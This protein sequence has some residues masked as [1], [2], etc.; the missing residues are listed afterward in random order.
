MTLYHSARGVNVYTIVG[1][2]TIVDGVVSGF[3]ANGYL[4]FSQ[5]VAA[6]ESLE[7]VLQLKNIP[8][9]VASSSAICS[10]SGGTNNI[11]LRIYENTSGRI[12]A[13]YVDANGTTVYFSHTTNVS[14]G[15]FKFSFTSTTATESYSSDGNEWTLLSTGSAAPRSLNAN[16]VN[17]GYITSS[18]SDW[19][20]SIDLKG[21]YIKVDEAAYFGVCPILVQKH[22]LR[23]PEIYTTVGTPTLTDGIASDFSTSNYFSTN[24]ISEIPVNFKM[25]TAFTAQ[26]L[27][28]SRLLCS[29]G[30]SSNYIGFTLTANGDIRFGLRSSSGTEQLVTSSVPY[31]P[32]TKYYAKAERNNTAL[33]ISVS[34]DKVNWTTDTTTVESGVY[35]LTKS[36]YVGVYYASSSSITSPFSGSIDLNETYIQL[37]GK[38]WLWQPRETEK[39]VVNG[40]EVWTK[41]V[42]PPTQERVFLQCNSAS[43]YV[44]ANNLFDLTNASTWEIQFKLNTGSNPADRYPIGSSIHTYFPDFSFHTVNYT[45]V[46]VPTTAGGSWYEVKVG[47]VFQTNT[48]Y[49][50]KYG[51]NNGS[52]YCKY[53][54][55]DGTTW[56]DNFASFSG[57]ACASS[58]YMRVGSD[59]YDSGNWYFNGVIEL[60][61]VKVYADNVLVFDGADS[62]QYTVYGSPTITRQANG[63]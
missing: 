5:S 11:V 49:F 32:G 1:S 47:S 13:S 21:S 62:T 12:V 2:P 57:S 19:G 38:L 14:Q 63:L 58:A 48:D 26:D 53:S 61:A 29:N 28:L 59:V 23:G 7:V 42:V 4:T 18:F 40:V 41:P 10:V 46:L 39:I 43:D 30:G 27:A 9:T 36:F 31:V 44:Q 24:S 37:N 51:Y 3:S 22:Q 54:T 25:A 55:D 34:T 60:S 52:Y 35:S 20:G 33:S 6:S 8:E 45:R 17:F 56:V 16:G 50:V 15:F